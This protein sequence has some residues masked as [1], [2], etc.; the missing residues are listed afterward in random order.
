MEMVN[1]VAIIKSILI[2]QN[3]ALTVGTVLMKNDFTA[4]IFL[5]VSI[6]ESSF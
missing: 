6:F 5:S 3:C 4:D 2:K 1:L